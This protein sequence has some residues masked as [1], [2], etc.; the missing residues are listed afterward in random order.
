[1]SGAG[2][3][4][5]L[6]VP[7]WGNLSVLNSHTLPSCWVLKCASCPCGG[8]FR[9]DHTGPQTVAACLSP[10]PLRPGSQPRP[11]PTPMVGGLST[12]RAQRSFWKKSPQ[13]LQLWLGLS[14]SAQTPD[15]ALG[16]KNPAGKRDAG[17][18]GLRDRP[19]GDQSHEGRDPQDEGGWR[20]RA[21]GPGRGPPP[22]S[23]LHAHRASVKLAVRLPTGLTSVSTSVL[24]APGPLQS[25]RTLGSVRSVP[26][27]CALC[28]PVL[29]CW[30]WS[31]QLTTHE[32]GVPHGR[33]Q[34]RGFRGHTPLLLAGTPPRPLPAI[35]FSWISR[36]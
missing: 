24:P 17:L 16:E 35:I 28:T 22:H 9:S 20:G 21:G 2:V 1:M 30:L 29:K 15:H 10:L 6:L 5:D 13:I 3:Q 25:S 32:W 23:D 33:S 4:V 27:A 31:P 12:P 11:S 18:S 26:S 7:E 14:S 19:D 36:P 8:V 34:G